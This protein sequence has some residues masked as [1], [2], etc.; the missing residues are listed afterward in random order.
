[1]RLKKFLQG[2]I[3]GFIP[4]DFTLPTPRKLKARL[5]NPEDSRILTPRILGIGWCINFYQL[6]RKLR[7]I[8]GKR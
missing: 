2:K 8:K 3:L 5:W 6:L 7:I 4:Y 1:M